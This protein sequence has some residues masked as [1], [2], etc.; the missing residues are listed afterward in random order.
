MASDELTGSP[1]D[2]LWAGEPSSKL[3]TQARNSLNAAGITTVGM[4]AESS[5]ADL[6]RL[7]Q[8]GPRRVEEAR[9]VLALRGLALKPDTV[10]AG[11]P[12][13]SPVGA[14]WEDQPKDNISTWALNGLLR[15]GIS[16]VG[17][18]VASSEADLRDIRNL[19]DKG[20]AEIRRVLAL[21]GLALSHG[22]LA[23]ASGRPYSV[24]ADGEWVVLTIGGLARRLGMKE[25]E[26][27]ELAY[28]QALAEVTTGGE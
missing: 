10:T 8:F 28:K 23:D 13:A 6:L 19:G 27:F 5:E 14:L 25:R 22:A 3:G 12:M 9:R 21:Q 24:R 20:L 2:L 1:V 7:R 26:E 16:T 11:S 4:L 17:Q 18:L 15:A